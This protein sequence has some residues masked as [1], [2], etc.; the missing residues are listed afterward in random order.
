MTAWQLITTYLV[1]MQELMDETWSSFI[2]WKMHLISMVKQSVVKVVTLVWLF[3][4]IMP[5]WQRNSQHWIFLP[6]KDIR[7]NWN[8]TLN[9]ILKTNLWCFG[10][11]E[12]LINRLFMHPMITSSRQPL[13]VLLLVQ[14]LV[15][16]FYTKS[17][18]THVTWPKR[19][20]R[21]TSM[22]MVRM[23]LKSQADMTVIR[24]MIQPANLTLKKLL[25]WTLTCTF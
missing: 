20:L 17:E 4:L 3:Q 6:V 15:M 21:Q 16:W 5:K 13:L 14:I 19:K 7:L 18:F 23:L 11:K 1:Q 24:C 10:K 2:K 25:L 22:L 8:W 12:H 9:P